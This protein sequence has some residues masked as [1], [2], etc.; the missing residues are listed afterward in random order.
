MT[1]VI[2]YHE[3]Y[4]CDT[5]CCGHAV[6]VDEESERRGFEFGSPDEGENLREY[7]EQLVSQELGPEHVADLDWENC[8]VLESCSC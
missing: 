1:K 7:A 3:R 6:Y 2:V 8:V 5:G 4:G